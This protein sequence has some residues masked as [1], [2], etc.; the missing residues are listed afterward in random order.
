MGPYSIS[1]EYEFYSY[2]VDVDVMFIYSYMFT[3][4]TISHI[5]APDK[6]YH[7]PSIWVDVNSYT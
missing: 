4:I 3:N 1:L 5:L 7:F 2:D 6:A